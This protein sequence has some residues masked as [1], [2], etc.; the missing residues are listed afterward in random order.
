MAV[1]GCLLQTPTRGGDPAHGQVFKVT[2]QG[3]VMAPAASWSFEPQLR[4]LNSPDNILHPPPWAG[5]SICEGRG[6]PLVRLAFTHDE[7]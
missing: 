5:S 2:F 4:V 1:T 7:R 3:A 6:A